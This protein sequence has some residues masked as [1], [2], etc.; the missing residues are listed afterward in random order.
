[1]VCPVKFFLR[2]AHY[3]L[4][5]PVIIIDGPVSVLQARDRIPHPMDVRRAVQMVI[6]LILFGGETVPA[7]SIV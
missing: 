5:D 4:H 6:G 7:N 1:M 2:L 3:A